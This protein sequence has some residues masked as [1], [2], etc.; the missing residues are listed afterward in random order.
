MCCTLYY[1]CA[2]VLLVR[3][4]ASEVTVGFVGVGL[5]THWQRNKG[6]GLP[7]RHYNCSM[8]LLTPGIHG[9]TSTEPNWWKW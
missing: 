4:S 6:L 8:L 7:I 1:E 9:A 5:G 3:L 2:I